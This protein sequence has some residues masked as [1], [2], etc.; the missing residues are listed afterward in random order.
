[1]DGCYLGEILFLD[2]LRSDAKAA[3]HALKDLLGD[4]RVIILSGDHKE[5]AAL[6]GKEVGISATYGDLMPIDKERFISE[7]RKQGHKVVMIGDGIND[8]PALAAADIGIAMGL[9]GTEFAAE[10][11]DAVLMQENLS[12]ITE[13]IKLSRVVVR[14]I[15]WN[16]FFSIIF[17]LI[18]IILGYLGLLNPVLAI[19]LQ[20][21]ATMTVLISSAMLLAW[22]SGGNRPWIRI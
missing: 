3:V 12:L 7:A 1:M 8:G 17:N 20:E 19:I 14:R 9:S 5:Q 2:T 10:T 15:K 18:G 21:A 6:T 11:A 13:F 22:N 16:I 4:E